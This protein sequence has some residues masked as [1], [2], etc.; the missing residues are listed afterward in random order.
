VTLLNQYEVQF[1]TFIKTEMKLDLAHDLNHILRVVKTTK[2]LCKQERAVGEIAIPAAYLHDCFSYPKDHPDRAQSSIM[3]AEKA[4]EFL[5]SINY[6]EYYFPD[7]H[8]AI[9]AHSFSANVDA[10]TLEAKIVQDADRLDALGAIGIARCIQVGA[11]LERQLYSSIDMFCDNR[12]PDDGTYTLDHFY[13]KLLT[14]AAS[15]KTPSGLTEAQSR[16]DFMRDYL[17]QLALEVQ[18]N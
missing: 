12:T 16:T 17:K 10:L 3:A 13:T 9:V 4:I 7:I 8:H 14:L 6:P 2:K 18:E 1:I 11:K 5:K 15:M